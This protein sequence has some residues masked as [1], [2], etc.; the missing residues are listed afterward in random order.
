MA[1]FTAGVLIGSV[2]MSGISEVLFLL[3]LAAAIF[4]VGKFSTENSEGHS[5]LLLLA[6]IFLVAASVG[7][8]RFEISEMLL[9]REGLQNLADEQNHSFEGEIADE[10]DVRER[11]VRLTVDLKTVSVGTTTVPVAGT[12]LVVAEVYPEFQFGDRLK[13]SGK[14]EAPK[15]FDSGTGREFDYVGYLA[16]EGITFVMFQPKIQK[17]AGGGG[18]PVKSF[19]FNLKATLIGNISDHVPEPDSSLLGGL[20]FGAKRSLGQTLLDDFRRAG[21]IHVVVLSGYNVT[22]VADSVMKFFSF[23]PKSFGSAFGA[24][25]II[26]FA[27]MT[28]ASA[29]IIRASVMSLLVIF[30]KSI[31][32]NY[33]ITRAL[34]LAGFLMILQNPRVLVFD[35]SFQLSFAATIAIIYVSP[36]VR[37]RLGFITEKIG[38]RDIVSATLSTQIFVLPL[39]LYMMG[40]L[41]IV[42]LPVNLLILPFVPMTMLFGFLLS[43][44]GFAGPLAVPFSIPTFFL[45]HYQL[46]VVE[47]FSHLPFAVVGI[48]NFPLAAVVA[49]YIVYTF[50]LVYLRRGKPPVDVVGK[51]TNAVYES[52]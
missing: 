44:A 12:I 49:V 40:Q 48:S 43:I 3:L 11:N 24:I 6:A 4:L 45:L 10:P 17:I 31:H 26:L 20:L 32:R 21:V 13:I 8:A 14:L 39:I 29:T 1:G 16:K 25:S 18:N 33:N 50:L 34:I 41:S 9:N 7:V 19:L 51:T 28:G 27:I 36:I 52:I 15:N 46:K 22:I 42:A 30:A 23:L 47:F 2:W 35:P 37:E 38:L 5:K